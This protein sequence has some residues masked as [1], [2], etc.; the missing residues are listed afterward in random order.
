MASV[1]CA[2][3]ISRSAADPGRRSLGR[4]LASLD[5]QLVTGDGRDQRKRDEERRPRSDLTLRPDDAALSFDDPLG[6]EEAETA[7]LA[8]RFVR[9]PV[10]LKEMG[11]PCR[12]DPGA[13]VPDRHQG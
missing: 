8:G 13:G 1:V 12:R 10:A 3:T 5:D 6:D 7:P 9:L 2:N 4:A 11:Q